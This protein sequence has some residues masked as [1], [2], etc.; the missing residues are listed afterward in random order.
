MQGIRV[1]AEAIVKVNDDMVRNLVRRPRHRLMPT[2]I[3]IF[4]A[5][6]AM[7]FTPIST[8]SKHIQH[9]PNITGMN[10]FMDFSCF[11]GA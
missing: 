6:C 3:E 1:R 10:N 8:C 5:F 11:P 2:N 4:I 7:F 9:I